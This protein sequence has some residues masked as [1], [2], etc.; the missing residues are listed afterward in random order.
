M[1]ATTKPARKPTTKPVATEG[2]KALCVALTAV[3]TNDGKQ[4]NVLKAAADALKAQYPTVKALDAIGTDT[5]GALKRAYAKGRLSADD[6]RVYGALKA[7]MKNWTDEQ[8]DKR[9]ALQS[10]VN[11]AWKRIVAHAY[12]VAKAKPTAKAK[13]AK[14]AAKPAANEG[15]GEGDDDASPTKGRVPQIDQWAKT[16]ATM[17]TQIQAAEIEGV[18]R[19]GLVAALR[20]ASSFLTLSDAAARTE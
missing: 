12:P 5:L 18:D 9:Q 1:T 14:P 10:D 8:K 2:F 11:K 13:T 20:T 19:G 3:G 15:E 16:L 6:L 17:L 7:E 4:V